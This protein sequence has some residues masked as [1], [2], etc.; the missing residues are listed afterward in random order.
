MPKRSARSKRR[1]HRSYRYKP[2]TIGALFTF[3][4]FILY[5]FIALSLIFLYQISL[6]GKEVK[7]ASTVDYQVLTLAEAQ[8]M[9]STSIVIP[10]FISVNLFKDSNA[11]A[12]KDSGEPC[13][14]KEFYFKVNGVTRKRTGTQDCEARFVAVS[15]KTNKVKFVDSLSNWYL[16]G[17]YAVDKPDNT[18]RYRSLPI[19][20]LINGNTVEVSG[21]PRSI[22]G[23]IYNEVFIGVKGAS[24]TTPTPTP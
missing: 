12:K 7:G 1:A 21:F 14:K 22:E 23:G 17:M 2:S 19:Y 10:K 11:N 18:I 24:T 9:A 8:K 6:P 20:K 16:T 3:P 15:E 13:L 5:A 4:R